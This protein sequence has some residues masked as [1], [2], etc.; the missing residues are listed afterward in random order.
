LNE[1]CVIKSK[2]DLS[3][4]GKHSDIYPCRWVS[5]SGLHQ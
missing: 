1:N 2:A 5:F 4:T 3:G